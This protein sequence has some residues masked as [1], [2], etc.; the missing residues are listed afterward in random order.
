MQPYSNISE[1]ENQIIRKFDQNIDPEEL[2]WHRDERDR[3]VTVIGETDW[4]FQLDNEL[5]QP[6]KGTIKIPKKVYHR[7]I[8]GTGD[9]VIS[10]LES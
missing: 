1:K 10:I 8:K 2:M 6:M 7:T 3:E 9:L 4:L 5:P